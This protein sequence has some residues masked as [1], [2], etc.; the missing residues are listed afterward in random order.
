MSTLDQRRVEKKEEH[1]ETMARELYMGALNRS[2]EL[3]SVPRRDLKDA[4]Q[5]L[6]SLS[7]FMARVFYGVDVNILETKEGLPDVEK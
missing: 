5:K 7:Y 2:S 1:V 3:G 6:S 4:L